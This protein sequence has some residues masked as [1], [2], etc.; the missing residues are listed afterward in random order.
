MTTGRINQ[1]TTF[2]P[3]LI[4]TTL[5]LL[6]SQ[7]GVRQKVDHNWFRGLTETHSQL[8]AQPVLTYLSAESANQFHLVPQGPTF[9]RLS[10]SCQL[11]LTKI[12]AFKGN[13]LQLALKLSHSGFPTRSLIAHLSA[14]PL[15][16]SPHLPLSIANQISIQLDLPQLSID[17]VSPPKPLFLPSQY[18]PVRQ[19]HPW[20]GPEHASLLRHTWPSYWRLSTSQGTKYSTWTYSRQSQTS[21]WPAWKSPLSL[22][23]S[24]KHSH[25]VGHFREIP[26]GVTSHVHYYSTHQLLILSSPLRHTGPSVKAFNLTGCPPLL[27]MIASQPQIH[28]GF[29]PSM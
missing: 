27:C 10:S 13:C 5:L 6:L 16:T 21:F 20:L 7:S 14:L 26:K 17:K 12:T 24:S 2:R 8:S 3:H 25:F 18:K 9:F 19:T 4:L 1:V 29:Y 15:A 11:I 22:P 28:N 23:Y